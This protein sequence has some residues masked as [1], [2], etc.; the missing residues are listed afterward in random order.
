MSDQTPSSFPFTIKQCASLFERLPIKLYAK[1]SRGRFTYVNRSTHRAHIER[2]GTQFRR[3][4]NG[5]L[6]M[7]G[8]SDKD[9]F[10]ED[11]FS[12]TEN[13]EL[14]IIETGESIVDQEEEETWIDGSISQVLTSKLPLHDDTGKVIGI[15]GITKDTSHFHRTHEFMRALL[16]TL[17]QCVFV[18]DKKGVITW[19]NDSFAMWHKQYVGIEDVIGL[20]DNDLWPHHPELA[21]GFRGRDLEVIE[22]GT[23]SGRVREKHILYDR[24]IRIIDTHKFPYID[25]QDNI[26]GVIGVYE[27]VTDRVEADRTAQ[28]VAKSVGHSLGTCLNVLE[29]NCNSLARIVGEVPQV[30]RLRR[31]VSFL[32]RFATFATGLATLDDP[33]FRIVR[34]AEFLNETI[35]QFSESDVPVRLSL[36]PEDITAELSVFHARLALIE[37]ASNAIRFASKGKQESETWVKVSIVIKHEYLEI[38]VRDSG[39]GVVPWLKGGGLFQPK[40]TSGGSS[41]AGLGLDLVRRV[42]LLHSGEVREI[43]K[44]DQ[45][46]HFV[47]R[48]PLNRSSGDTR[49]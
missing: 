15:V 41:H 47:L 32:H 20:T 2:V 29:A 26:I 9:F 35:D 12:N 44:P 8:K 39:P 14:R 16:N 4:E 11:H 37:L 23:P 19:C 17:P 40:T 10:T 21:R 13:D 1:D 48:L 25:A 33:D 46:A 7:L 31:S 28:A 45:G 3:D 5:P 42:A 30:A 38:H 18:K 43:G 6:G 27:D 22:S 24:S 49:Q 36:P 34:V